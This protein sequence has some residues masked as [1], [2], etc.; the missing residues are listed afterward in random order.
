MSITACTFFSLQKYIFAC[1]NKIWTKKLEGK[2]IVGVNKNFRNQNM[3]GKKHFWGQFF[4]NNFDPKIL[5]A[6]KKFEGGGQQNFWG[7]IFL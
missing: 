3:L 2:I 7:Q 1:L 6:T 5:G 4:L